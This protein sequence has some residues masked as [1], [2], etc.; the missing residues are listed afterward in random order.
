[1]SGGREGRFEVRPAV[2]RS[3]SNSPVDLAEDRA[4]AL[5]LTLVSRETVERLDRFAGLLLDWQ[6]R[7]NLI[8][9]STEPVL[10]TRHIAD[11]LQLLALAPEARVWADLGSGAGF[12]GLVIACALAD[13]PGAL[14]HLVESNGKKTAFLRDAARA[15]EAPVVV[16]AV[17]VADFAKNAPDGI[18]AVTAR[19]FAPLPDLLTAA[20][21]LLKTGALGLFPKGQNVDAELTEA[22]KCWRFQ[23]TLAASRTDPKARIIVVRSLESIPGTQTKRNS[24]KQ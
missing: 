18:E 14:V 23:E 17:R 21:P 20:Y 2:L 19:A 9:P 11:S 10:W 15:T 12:P 22:A 7:V 6:R 5:A 13:C 3:R 16:H 4:Q 1:M 8:A 24:T